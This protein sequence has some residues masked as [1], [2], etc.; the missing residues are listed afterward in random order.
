MW[1]PLGLVAREGRRF[2]WSFVDGLAPGT[3]DFLGL[4]Y[5]M[6]LQ[7]QPIA[8]MRFAGLL[9][10][11]A[12]PGTSDMG[13][14]IDASG[15]EEVLVAA[16]E[17]YGKPL[18]VT[19]NGVAD[20]TD[21]LRPKFLEDHVAAM[22]RAMARGARVQGYFHW[23]LVDNFEWHEGYAPRFGFFEVDYA[24]QERRERPSAAVYRKVIA[25][26]RSKVTS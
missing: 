23:S 16:H 19:E 18:M 4:N 17:R 26:R 7:A 22:E 9:P 1:E 11:P 5:Y 6:A 14:P 24:T 20:A 13:W 12:R 8:A 25:S 10:R 15:F 2:N 3:V 21:A